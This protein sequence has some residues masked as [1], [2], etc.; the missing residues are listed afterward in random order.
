LLIPF[1]IGWQEFLDGKI[2]CF[3]DDKIYG[4]SIEIGK[5]FM[6]PGQI[7]SFK[8]LMKYKFDVF[9]PI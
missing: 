1:L 3:A 9:D 8:L 7:F 6:K 4:F 5:I 2:F